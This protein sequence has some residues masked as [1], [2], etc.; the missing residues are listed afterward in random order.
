[1][2]AKMF[3]GQPDQTGKNDTGDFTRFTEFMK[4]LV[5]VPHSAIKAQLDQEKR[6]KKRKRASRASSDRVQAFLP[7]LMITSL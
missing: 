1:M 4:R 3:A 5:A 7:P 2:R 6:E